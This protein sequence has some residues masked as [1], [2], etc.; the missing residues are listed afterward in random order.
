MKLDRNINPD[1]R[2]K[3]ALIKLRKITDEDFNEMLE[4][5]RDKRPFA[6]PS[7]ALTLGDEKGEQFF[8][9]KYK[10]KRT[11]P[12]L[13]A[14]AKAVRDEIGTNKRHAA[15]LEEFALEIEQEADQAEVLATS[16]E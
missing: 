11:A 12:A 7:E 1:G 15:D 13:R 9:L 2:G 4:S 10:D 14:Y 16:H 3:Y 5:R 6:L 8:V